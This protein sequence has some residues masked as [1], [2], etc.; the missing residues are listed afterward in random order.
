VAWAVASQRTAP[1]WGWWIGQGATTLWEEW[2][3]SSSRNHIMYGD[4]LAWFYKALAGLNPDPSAPGFKHFTLQPHVVGDLTWVR[5]HHDCPFGRIE[6]NWRR[7]GKRLLFDAII[8]PNTTATVMLPCA[9]PALIREG[10]HPLDGRVAGIKTLDAEDGWSVMEV[11]SGSYHFSLPL[12][13]S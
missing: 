13:G 7:D 2:N 11:E 9:A 4:I 3:G 6:A 5:S 8:P 12:P 1:S 10:G